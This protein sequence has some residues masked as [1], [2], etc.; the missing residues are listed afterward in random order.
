MLI[1]R[2]SQNFPIK[3][4]NLENVGSNGKKKTFFS[5]GNKKKKAN[6]VWISVTSDPSAA[7]SSQGSL[8]DE[9]II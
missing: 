4:T 9:K 1:D 7:S 8:E 6:S 5:M 2:A 3:C